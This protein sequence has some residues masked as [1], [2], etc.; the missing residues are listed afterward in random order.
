MEGK[1]LI[2]LPGSIGDL[3]TVRVLRI[4]MGTWVA[5]V[6]VLLSSHCKLEGIPG[7]EFLHCAVDIGHDSAE[8]EE[9]GGDPCEDSGCCSFETAQYHANRHQDVA[10]IFPAA[11]ISAAGSGVAQDRVPRGDGLPVPT[12]APPELS[13]SWRFFSRAALPPRAP[14]F[15]S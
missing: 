13:G 11:M 14:C 4:A 10:A 15:A 8:S 5:L 7:F 3:S 1:E 6:W 12:M 2:E 9:S